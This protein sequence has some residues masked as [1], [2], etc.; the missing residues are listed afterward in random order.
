MTG[1]TLEDCSLEMIARARKTM[2]S[3]A[4]DATA[5]KGVKELK[6]VGGGILTPHSE[7]VGSGAGGGLDRQ[8]RGRAVW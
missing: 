7:R 5:R 3:L 8:K 6:T 1:V 2:C 4:C